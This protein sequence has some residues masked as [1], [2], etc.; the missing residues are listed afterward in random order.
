M[1]YRV[2]KKIRR[3][4]CT[5]CPRRISPPRLFAKPS[6]ISTRGGF[7]V[8]FTYL[9]VCSGRV[10]P[11]KIIDSERGG[12]PLVSVYDV[13]LFSESSFN[14]SEWSQQQPESFA[15]QLF[16]RKLQKQ[17]EYYSTG[18]SRIVNS[19]C[20]RARTLAFNEVV[21][22]PSPHITIRQR[23][24]VPRSTQ[25]HRRPRLSIHKR[26]SK[27]LFSTSPTILGRLDRAI[28]EHNNADD[29]SIH[30]FVEFI[31][32]VVCVLQVN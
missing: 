22:C 15:E 26:P 9:S 6:I 10:N 1:P 29:C 30:R 7:W 17:I 20:A 31:L 12:K 13:R 27:R 24:R 4:A 14:F 19:A 11:W 28:S 8:N 23:A 21:K 18:F 3:D 16:R 32:D 5:H 2:D 25:Y